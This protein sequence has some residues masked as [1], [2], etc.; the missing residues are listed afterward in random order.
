MWPRS[1]VSLHTVPTRPTCA[2]ALLNARPCTHHPLL[3]RV[4]STV[5]DNTRPSVPTC[6]PLS[7]P[8]VPVGLGGRLDAPAQDGGG[9]SQAAAPGPLAS[10]AGG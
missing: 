9:V 1:P 3:P 2:C 10:R 5:G 7:L 6:L 8:H 4:P